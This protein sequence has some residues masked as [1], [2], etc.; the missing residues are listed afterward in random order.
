MQLGDGTTTGSSKPVLVKKADGG[1]LED[2]KLMRSTYRHSCAVVQGGRVYCWG[3]NRSGQLGD[4]TTT[5]RLYAIATKSSSDTNLSGVRQVVGGYRYSCALLQSKEVHCWGSNGLNID[6]ASFS[7]SGIDT[8]HC[9]DHVDPDSAADDWDYRPAR[10]PGSLWCPRRDSH[11]VPRLGMLGDTGTNGKGPIPR[12]VAV[13]A[14]SGVGNLSNV[15][16]IY[17]HSRHTCALLESKQLVCWGDNEDGQ[18][19]DR[20][21]ASRGRPVFVQADSAGTTPLGNIEHVGMYMSN[22]CALSS[23]A[24]VYCW[25]SHTQG[26]LGNGKNNGGNTRYAVPIRGVS[27]AREMNNTRL[28]G[29]MSNHSCL[30]TKDNRIACWGHGTATHRGDQAAPV[31]MF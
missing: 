3:R 21:R 11:L 28:L 19:G 12:P 31:L 2:V 29:T 25:G 13:R 26:R 18:L 17:S 5:R 15:H 16:S 4:G 24:K 27:G 6:R 20:S 7:G 22:T 8:S 14:V 10:F 30:I 23:D 1:I 9:Y